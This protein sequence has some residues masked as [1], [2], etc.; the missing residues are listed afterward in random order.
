MNRR[1]IAVE[2]AFFNIEQ[3]MLRPDHPDKLFRD[4]RAYR[5]VF[6]YCHPHAPSSLLSSSI[7]VAEENLDNGFHP[8]NSNPFGIVAPTI[9]TIA[10]PPLLL[11]MALGP[12]RLMANKMAT[13]C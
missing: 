1:I 11:T 13:T 5:A 4:G 8:Y 9:A 6:L 2:R 12:K 7:V 10:R 3:N